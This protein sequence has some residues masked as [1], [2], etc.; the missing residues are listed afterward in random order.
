L[1]LLRGTTLDLGFKGVI[2]FLAAF[3]LKGLILSGDLGSGL[4]IGET[5]DLSWLF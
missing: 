3:G 5:D 1:S 2:G 4:E